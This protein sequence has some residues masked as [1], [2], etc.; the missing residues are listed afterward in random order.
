MGILLF[1]PASDHLADIAITH[2][3]GFQIR[4]LLFDTIR[5][6]KGVSLLH[7]IVVVLLALWHFGVNV[8]SL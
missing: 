7:G 6:G 4:Q 8:Y 5:Q 1:L 3:S 2:Q